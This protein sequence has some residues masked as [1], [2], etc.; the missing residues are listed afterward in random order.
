ML[1][2]VSQTKTDQGRS[3][4]GFN[5]F[6]AEDQRLFEAIVRGEHTIQGLRHADLQ[7]P[8]PDRSPGQIS[9]LIRRLRVHGLLKRVGHTYK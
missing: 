8:L 4:E 5:F 2:K 7:R 9:R 3:Y 1:N 6:S